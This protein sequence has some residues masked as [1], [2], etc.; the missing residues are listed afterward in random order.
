MSSTGAKIAAAVGGL[1][2]GGGI[3]AF[4]AVQKGND[5]A[6]RGQL[7]SASLTSQ[8]TA[9]QTLLT[10][11]GTAMQA[12]LQSYAQQA[13]T[14]HLAQAYGLTADRMTRIQRLAARLGVA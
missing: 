3:V 1:L 8:G 6:A 9:L 12:R 14:D 10:A 13:A 4:L 5:L 7:L 2:V 11:D